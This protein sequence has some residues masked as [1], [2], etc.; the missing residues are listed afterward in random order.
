MGRF[1]SPVDLSS[2]QL[3]AQSLFHT[4]HSSS[5]DNK[6]SRMKH[7]AIKVAQHICITFVRKTDYHCTCLPSSKHINWLIAISHTYDQ[8]VLFRGRRR[9]SVGVETRG[10]GIAPNWTRSGE[11]KSHYEG[12][13]TTVE[14]LFPSHIMST[15]SRRSTLVLVAMRMIQEAATELVEPKIMMQDDDLHKGNYPEEMFVL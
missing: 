11:E 3:E 2:R 8:L 9:K 12:S 4:H 7:L 14:H 6:F 10:G 1:N 13:F 15:F 5:L